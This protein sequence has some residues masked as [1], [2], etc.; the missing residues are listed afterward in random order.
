MEKI[1]ATDRLKDLLPKVKAFVYDELLPLEAGH[2]SRSA[3]E[4]YALLDAKREKVRAAGLWGLH[5][6]KNEG[7]WGL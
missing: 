5:L 4:T 7:G 1:F 6:P 2:H 3:A